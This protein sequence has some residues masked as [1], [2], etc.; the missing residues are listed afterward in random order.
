MHSDA[1]TDPDSGALTG[2]KIRLKDEEHL[3]LYH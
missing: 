3:D 2:R 1:R